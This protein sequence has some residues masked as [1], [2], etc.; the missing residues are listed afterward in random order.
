M[1][2]GLLL[3]YSGLV[4]WGEWH[5]GMMYYC[6]HAN[7]YIPSKAVGVHPLGFSCLDGIQHVRQEYF[8]LMQSRILQLLVSIE[9]SGERAA[10]LPDAFTPADKAS[11]N[12][13]K[14]S[15]RSDREDTE[16]EE[17][18]LSTTPLALL[19]ACAFPQIVAL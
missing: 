4:Q 13:H 12:G 8:L 11:A 2:S 6:V 3:K 19:Q 14:A 18:L 5:F 7:V 17:E 1:Q 15:A 9:D 16:E 10:L